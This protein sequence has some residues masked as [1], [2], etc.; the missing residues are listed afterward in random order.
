MRT[1]VPAVGPKNTTHEGAPAMRSTA[2]QEL[3]R[4]CLSTLLFES[5]FYESGMK[6]SERVAGLVPQCLPEAVATLAVEARTKMYLRHLPLFLVRELARI[7]GNG[8]IVADTL[9]QIIERPDELTEFLAIYWKDNPDAPVSAGVK[10]GLGAAFR[11][12][13][14]ATLAKYDR[15]NMVKLRDVL[16]LVHPRPE[17]YRRKPTGLFEKP[18]VTFG[19]GAVWG[20]VIDRSLLTPDT[21]E[22]ALSSGADKKEV[23]ERLLRE[24]KLGGLAFLRNLRNMIE[25]GV[26]EGLIRARFEGGFKYVLP[27]RFIAAATHAPRF[28]DVIEKAMLAACASLPK[29]AGTT[30]LVIDTSP[31]MWQAKISLKSEL[32]RF[33]AAA[34]LAILTREVCENANVYAFNKQAYEIAPRRGFALRDALSATLANYSCGGLAV[35]M[36]NARGYDRIIVI[37]DGQWHYSSVNHYEMGPAKKVSPPPLTEKAYMINV[38]SYQHVFSTGRWKTIDGWSERVLDFVSASENEELFS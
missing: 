4:A 11:K 27:F 36:A 5:Q 33:D 29:L 34:A 6:L 38:A 19:Q 12:F 28:E 13:D 20:R 15:D 31:S 8:S 18:V 30:A 17:N 24:K 9:A 3:R 22:V 21:W 26:D 2:L 1:N 25:A 7:K 10:R 14:E 32:S 37:T 23:F 16:R 35:A